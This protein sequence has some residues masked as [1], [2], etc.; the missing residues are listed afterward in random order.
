M[1]DPND[2]FCTKPLGPWIAALAVVGVMLLFWVIMR[3]EDINQGIETE[4]V[5]TRAKIKMPKAGEPQ[6]PSPVTQAAYTQAQAITQA[7]PNGGVPYQP[8]QN[9]SSNYKVAAITKATPNGGMQLVANT[10]SKFQNSLKD[11]V[12]AIIP[13]VCD[14]HAIRVVRTNI[15]KPADAQNMQFVPPFDGAIDKFIENKG[16][17]NVGAGIVIDERGYVL[18]NYHVTKDAT[19]IIVTV[20]GNPSRDIRAD[21]VAEEPNL[22]LALVKLRA[23]GPFPEVKLGDSSFSQIG[24]YVVAVGSPF[25]IE[26]TVT[27]GIISGIRKSILIEGIR[28]QN[29]FQTDAPINRGSSGG[30]LVD[31]NGD[32]IGINTAIYAPTGVFSGTGF[33][34]PINDCKDFLGKALKRNFPLPVDRKGML[35]AALPT[36]NPAPGAPLPVRFG[37][38]V[39]PINEIIARQFKISPWKGVLVNR[40]LDE[41]PASFAGIQRGDIV[42][43]IAGVPIKSAEDIRNVVAHFKSGDGVNVRILRNGKT[44]E[45]LVKIQ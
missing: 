22:D 12:N 11:A 14:I 32:V 33:A 42:V 18:T 2:S 15:R 27:S 30:P 29:L 35:A 28:Y 9:P 25:G 17:E 7:L 44:D 20:F 16:Y 6:F 34:I 37:L 40:V 23:D 43:A 36:T 41:S 3:H 1:E 8:N 19:D 31:L 4:T 10:D 5:N 39:M 21:I 45:I 26:Q 24:D 13:S 38:E